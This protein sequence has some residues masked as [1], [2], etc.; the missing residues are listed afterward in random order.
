MV[1]EG[2]ILNVLIFF[3]DI[4]A[5]N[6]LTLEAHAPVRTPAL[7]HGE[8]WQEVPCGTQSSGV[9]QAWMTAP[10]LLSGRDDSTRCMYLTFSLCF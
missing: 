4:T 5:D 8:W 6:A 7:S 3:N 10:E 1:E 9:H 2:N